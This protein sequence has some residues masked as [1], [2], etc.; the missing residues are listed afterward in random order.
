MNDFRTLAELLAA[1]QA[2][3]EAVTHLSGNKR[4]SAVWQSCARDLRRGQSVWKTL[5]SHG[6]AIRYEAMAI[7]ATE[8]AGRLPEGLRWLAQR[9]EL[10]AQRA[11]RLSGRMLL[12]LFVTIIAVLAMLALRT[13]QG[14]PLVDSLLSGLG[15]V[16]LVGGLHWLAVQAVRLEPARY[17]APLWSAGL[18]PTFKLARQTFEQQFFTVLGWQLDA[19]LDAAGALRQLQELYDAASYRRY[20]E[21]AREAVERGESLAS[22]LEANGLV[23]S[24]NLAQTLRTGEASGRLASALA[25]DLRLSAETLDL[26]IEAWLTWLPRAYYLALAVM[27]IAWLQ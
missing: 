16:A 25:H 12:P 22:A 4:Q 14:R 19:G 10:R 3:A 8:H 7:A 2:P 6:L 17:L 1:G 15:M 27:L 5:R 23:F 26:R 11:K 21:Q 13:T 24:A 18:L 20:V 9:S